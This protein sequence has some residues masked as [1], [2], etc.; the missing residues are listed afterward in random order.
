MNLSQD[1]RLWALFTSSTDEVAGDPLRQGPYES[2][3]AWVR[4]VVQWVAFR[5]DVELIIKVH[6]NLGGNYYIGKA[7]DELRIYQE[8][9]SALPANV[10][11][12]CRKIR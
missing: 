11:M 12:C 8:M 7:V 6:P 4:D 10:R 9:K 3:V 5:D 2:Q 1:K